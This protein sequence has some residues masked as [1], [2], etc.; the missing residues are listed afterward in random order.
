[1]LAGLKV[2]DYTLEA[3][4][5]QK[6]KVLTTIKNVV[7]KDG[8]TRTATTTSKNAQGQTVNN[9]IIWEKQ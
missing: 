6:G 5:K 7:S 8:K 2:D 1:M 9:S 4:T 3:T